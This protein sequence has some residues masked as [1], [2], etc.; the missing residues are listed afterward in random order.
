MPTSGI[1]LRRW[2][3]PFAFPSPQGHQAEQ[4]TLS[5]LPTRPTKLTD[6]RAKA[7]RGG[8]SVEL[9]AIEP[10]RLRSLVRQA[11]MRHVTL[12][13]IAAARAAEGADRTRLLTLAESFAS[14]PRRRP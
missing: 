14:V 7:W 5:H 2:W 10:E 6:T 3:A 13:H 4:I 8:D 9:D 1:V 12:D 11:I